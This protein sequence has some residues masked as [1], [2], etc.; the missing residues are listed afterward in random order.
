[1]HKKLLASLL[2][3]TT[4]I[5]TM[6]TDQDTKDRHKNIQV[7]WPIGQT[8]PS[9]TYMHASYSKENTFEVGET[10]AIPNSN[11][12]GTK[13]EYMQRY[14]KI[15]GLYQNE[16]TVRFIR[17]KHELSAP[18]E[19]GKQEII[20]AKYMSDLST[21]HPDILGKFPAKIL[22]EIVKNKK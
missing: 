19:S 11:I 21:K 2:I 12:F 15:V 8:I 6:Q 16:I 14:G 17:Y 4:S 13:H 7:E 18:D 1:M 3:C 20:L 9:N 10:V 22:A 5:V